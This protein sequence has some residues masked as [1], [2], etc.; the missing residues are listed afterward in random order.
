M[1]TPATKQKK[2]YSTKTRIGHVW[3]THN[4]YQEPVG[5]FEVEDAN[6]TIL[7]DI[8]KESSEEND[9]ESIDN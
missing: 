6:A 8:Q 1:V 3:S 9:M 5:V 7:K 2:P 4:H